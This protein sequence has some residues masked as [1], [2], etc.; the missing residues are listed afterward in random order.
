MVRNATQHGTRSAHGAVLVMLAVTL[1]V[2]AG[3]FQS[4]T[5]V[6]DLQSST[7]SDRV[8]TMELIRA[9]VSM[10]DPQAQELQSPLNGWERAE[11]AVSADTQPLVP[12][13]LE[14]I[15]SGAD[16]LERRQLVALVGVVADFQRARR[17]DGGPRVG[18]RPG[19]RGPRGG[20]GAP[21]E[22][23]G[24]FADLDLSEAQ[25]QAIAAARAQM[26]ATL[27]PL[28]EQ[29]KN[30]AIT[31]EAFQ[32]AARA[33]RSEFHSAVQEILTP[34]Q[35]AL[36]QQKK[37]ERMI[38][39]LE[40]H[41]AR[42]AEASARRLALLTRILALDEAQVSAIRGIHAEAGTQLAAILTGLK[43]ASLT[44]EQARAA[45]RE[46]KTSTHDA[47]VAQ[48]T[49]EQVDLLE[50]LRAI[51]PRGKRHGPRG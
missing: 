47:I 10:S 41:V 26:R 12:P 15:A 49:E 30:G 7:A 31:K 19:R 6:S 40:R 13:A 33:A 48:L 43:D 23:F 32:E 14:F 34:E 8:P 50:Q 16:I 51:H 11:R 44:P 22:G 28:R 17:A 46:L 1:F 35:R 29:V 38:E 39:R 25:R 5:E 20:F 36:L 37:A 21:H 18:H 42:H 45:W 9:K 24:A 3:C 4:S 2:A 27:Q